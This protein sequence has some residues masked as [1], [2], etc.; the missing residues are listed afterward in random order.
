MSISY[1]Y[2]LVLFQLLLFSFAMLVIVA[3]LFA[4]FLV[5]FPGFF[6]D[7]FSQLTDLIGNPVEIVIKVLRFSALLYLFKWIL[8]QLGFQKGPMTFTQYMIISLCI[9]YIVF[10]PSQFSPEEMVI[11]AILVLVSFYKMFTLVFNKFSVKH[12]KQIE[13]SVNR[14]KE[15]E[16]AAFQAYQQDQLYDALSHYHKALDIYKSP[17]LAQETDLNIR[18]AKVLEKIGVVLYKDKEF[19]IALVRFHQA[20]DFY[21]K[22]NEENPSL[23]NDRIRLLNESALILLKLGRRQ[24]ALKRYQLISELT[25]KPSIPKNFFVKNV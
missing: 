9:A 6:F 13:E 12:K 21:K 15:F 10:S 17:I 22:P 3:F 18:R 8:N 24:E 4:Q 7:L 11:I 2:V 23:I 5:H 1:E 25:G 19:E 14:A 20:L 16:R